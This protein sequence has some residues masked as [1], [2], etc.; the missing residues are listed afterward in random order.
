MTGMGLDERGCLA[1]RRIEAELL[2]IFKKNIHCLFI[3]AALG[4]RCSMQ[5]LKL[6]HARGI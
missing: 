2:Q 6:W 3:L 4:L 1:G 5:V